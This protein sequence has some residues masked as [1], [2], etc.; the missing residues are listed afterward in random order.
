MREPDSLATTVRG[1]LE[2]DAWLE[3]KDACLAH[4]ISAQAFYASR[5]QCRDRHPSDQEVLE[6][7]ENRQRQA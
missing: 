3:V 5:R 6:A 1:I 4:G 7:L 2:L